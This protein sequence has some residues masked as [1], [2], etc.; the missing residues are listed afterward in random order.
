MKKKDKQ[1]KKL[2]TIFVLLYFSL[3]IFGEKKMMYPVS[4]I[5]KELLTNANAVIRLQSVEIF[6]NSKK[7]F[8]QKEHLVVTIMNKS[9]ESYASYIEYYDKN[10]KI[11][12]FSATLY[13]KEG[14]KTKKSKSSEIVDVSATSGFSLYEDDRVKA[15]NLEGAEFPFTVE[16]YS[17]KRVDG[18][19]FVPG[20]VMLSATKVAVQKTEYTVKVNPDVNFNFKNLNGAEK[21]YSTSK[22]Q[23]YLVHSWTASDIKAEKWED[24]QPSMSEI[25]PRVM[26]TVN[27]F[28]YDG[29]DGNM[30]SWESFGNWINALNQGR[31]NISDATKND[32]KAI[33][34]RT[35]NKRNQVKA[36]YEYMQKRTRYVSIQVGIGG[37]QPFPAET[38][39]RLGYG[40]CKALSNYTLALLQEAG[41]KSNYVSIN[42]GSNS[43]LYTDF[44]SQ[45][46]N[47]AI[48]AVPMEKDTM[49]L[50]CTSQD[51]PANFTAGF[52]DDRYALMITEAGGKLVKT[53][54]YSAQDNSQ[55]LN[56]SITLDESGAAIGSVTV[57][58]KGRQYNDNSWVVK[59]DANEQ[60]KFIYNAFDAFGYEISEFAFEEVKSEDPYLKLNFK[61]TTNNLGS[62]SDS[63]FII[64]GSVLSKTN[65]NV[66][67]KTNRKTPVEFGYAYC[68]TDSVQI[69]L[70]KNFNLEFAPSETD[71]K[72]EFGVYNYNCKIEGQKLIYSRNL[73]RFK[74]EY[75]PE[76]FNSYVDFI[77]NQS[78]S[79][80]QKIAFK[81]AA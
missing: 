50:E 6:L 12:D 58:W 34:E 26:A 28:N 8:V 72:T 46:F 42:G 53:K 2:L 31:Q 74:G 76:K 29:F 80:K 68:D 21:Y 32:I 69:N 39:D 63:R 77:R 23:E 79:D 54:K 16:F 4:D 70:P 43:K 25:S 66:K 27:D 78:S 19:F 5:S 33:V 57:V 59:K 1:M 65:V 11:L 13:D 24:Y 45:Q 30:S 61:F 18:G 60:K 15:V 41:I 48:L 73:T 7:E 67:K 47:H 40:D 81:K 75:A 3:N 35:P 52:T 20:W 10:S 55:N 38:V 17:E 56:A 36:I 49:W 22:E 9:G 64:E 51:N 37:F 44:P 14:K 62:L 71:I